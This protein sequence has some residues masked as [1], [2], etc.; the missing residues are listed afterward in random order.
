MW[1][2]YDEHVVPERPGV[3]TLDHLPSFLT[4]VPTRLRPA[5]GG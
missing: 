5:W 3:V 4:A 1:Q 2:V